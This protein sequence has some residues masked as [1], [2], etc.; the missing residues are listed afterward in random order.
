M[1]T[2]ERSSL[3]T[4]FQDIPLYKMSQ[5]LPRCIY[6]TVVITQ[7][8]HMKFLLIGLQAILC[9]EL[10]YFLS[11]IFPVSTAICKLLWVQHIYLLNE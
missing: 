1:V 7:L 8:T 11:V 5:P 9:K 10:V 6:F 2:P 3:V 4:P